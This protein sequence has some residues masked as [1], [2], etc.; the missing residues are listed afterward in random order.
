MATNRH[1]RTQASEA[2]TEDTR[3]LRGL[4]FFVVAGAV[5]CSSASSLQ[6]APPPL[7]YLFPAG[8]QRGHSAEITAAGSFSTWPVKG[9]VSGKGVAVT[10]SKDKGKLSLVVEADAEPGVR[11]LRLFNDEGASPPRPFVIGT[12]PEIT[13][14]EPNDDYHK[15][16]TLAGS[17]FVVNG[18]L[19]QNGDVDHFAVPLK[20]G[21]T[22]VASVAANQALGSPMDGVIQLLSPDGVVVAENNDTLDL[23]P[24]VAFTAPRDGTYVARVFAF[25]AMPD[26]SIRFAGGETFIYRLTLTTGGFADHAFPLALTARRPG[27]VHF[28]GWNIPPELTAKIDVPL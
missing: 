21:Q 23:D 12:L 22:L 13:E 26:S 27:T 28:A 16:Q 20:K 7:T 17:T 18:R 5:V 4:A 15:P 9:W 24:Q 3:R 8:A 11:W 25:P 19:A 10:A 2:N 6:A 14:S 1:K